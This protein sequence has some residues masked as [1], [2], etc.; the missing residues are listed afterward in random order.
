[1]DREAWWAAVYG[2]AQSRTRL[3]QLSSSSSVYMSVLLENDH[4]DFG[5]NNRYWRECVRISQGDLLFISY[6]SSPG[7]R[8]WYL[9]GCFWVYLCG[10]KWL[11]RFPPSCWSW[12][13]FTSVGLYHVGQSMI[14]INPLQGSSSVC[15][16]PGAFHTLCT[17]LRA[18]FQDNVTASK[19][20]IEKLGTK[21]VKPL[22]QSY[23]AHTWQN[24]VSLPNPSAFRSAVYA[25]HPKAFCIFLFHMGSLRCSTFWYLKTLT[26]I[27]RIPISRIC[28]TCKFLAYDCPL[29]P[30]SPEKVLNSYWETDIRLEV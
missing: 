14:N 12:E 21:E 8:G 7:E 15:H 17:S 22:V 24:Q 6:L 19:L 5:V 1:M 29:S 9:D 11:N 4:S 27:K 25:L 18:I 16:I 30:C 28:I 20:L 13:M 10:V 23:I 2:V 26:V 3:K